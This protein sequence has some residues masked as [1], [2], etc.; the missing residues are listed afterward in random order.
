L[1]LV[2]ADKVKWKRNGKREEIKEGKKKLVGIDWKRAE[3]RG[4]RAVVF[5][6]VVSRRVKS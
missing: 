6:S 1:A 2:V 4:S 5:L 3:L